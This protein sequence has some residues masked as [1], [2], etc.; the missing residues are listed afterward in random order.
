MAETM[1]AYVA[2][3]A[4]LSD[5]LLIVRDNDTGTWS[6]FNP[7]PNIEA[8]SL[9]RIQGRAGLWGNPNGPEII[10]PHGG[11]SNYLY[12][13]NFDGTSWSYKTE[14]T[15]WSNAV[16]IHGTSSNDVYAA[17]DSNGP[18]HMAVYHYDGTNWA[19]VTGSGAGSDINPVGIWASPGGDVYATGLNG[20]DAI[21]KRTGGVWSDILADVES[22][23]GENISPG[24]YSSVWGF[25]N[26]D[27]WIVGAVTINTWGN[28]IH[29]DGVTW[30]VIAS[31]TPLNEQG[32]VWGYDSSNVWMAH[33]YENEG[34]GNNLRYWN[35]SSLSNESISGNNHPINKIYGKQ[36]GSGVFLTTVGADGEL[37]E[38]DM[39]TGT[40]SAVASVADYDY[41]A[42]LSS[43]DPDPNVGLPISNCS[44]PTIGA[45]FTLNHHK[46]LVTQHRDITNSGGVLTAP[47]SL[48]TKFLN[49]RKPK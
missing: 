23:I 36:N 15:Q 30:S 5:G 26:D 11:P 43:Y 40:W 7:Q 16:R 22:D 6:E 2:D 18:E 34:G 21:W 35:G 17:C 13:A 39:D 31:G 14:T 47:F 42:D 29:Y 32:C 10:M 25:S 41:W 20:G 27:V 49:I 8:N 33:T 12:M 38:R 1:I 37:F 24:Y 9:L 28:I 48:G 4:D 45:D 46:C 44:L 19:I 3:P